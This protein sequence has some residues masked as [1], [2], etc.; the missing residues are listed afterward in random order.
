MWFAA[1]GSVTL[2]VGP[3]HA[4]VSASSLA[5]P[6]FSD[7]LISWGDLFLSGDLITNGLDSIYRAAAGLSLAD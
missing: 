7:V 1:P 5:L 6:T 3:E 4:D 2:T